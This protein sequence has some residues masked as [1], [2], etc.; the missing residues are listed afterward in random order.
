MYTYIYADTC[1]Y[2]SDRA[3][4]GART[5]SDPNVPRSYSYTAATMNQPISLK[6]SY[7]AGREPWSNPL[8]KALSSEHGD[9][10][11]PFNNHAY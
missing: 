4:S 9:P 2:A 5:E 10:I 3:F 6:A 7:L 1:T 11:Q 8:H